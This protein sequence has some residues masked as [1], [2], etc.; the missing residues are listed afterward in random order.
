MKL[1]ELNISVGRIVLFV[2]IISRCYLIHFQINI[3]F[4]E[5][6]SIF[7]FLYSF[8]NLANSEDGCNDSPLVGGWNSQKLDGHLATTFGH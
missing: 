1:N 4:Y 2:V 5:S 8:D 6:Y 7:K 3:L